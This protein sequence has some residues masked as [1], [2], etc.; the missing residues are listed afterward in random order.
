MKILIIGSWQ[1]D[2]AILSKKEAELIGK[3]LAEKEQ[4]LI[5]GGGEGVSEIVV[6]SYKKN[7][8]QKYVCYIPSKEQM[9]I[10]GEKIGP[11]PDELIETNLDYP[12]RNIKMVQ[13]C[14]AVIALNG[15][16]GTLTEII[17]AVKDYNKKVSVVDF[18]E[19]SSWIKAIPELHKKVLITSD[20]NRAIE[21]II[22]I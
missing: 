18:G 8:G 12:Q 15:G 22:T 21:Q 19:L 17:H 9:R 1:K 11:K 6:K 5:S 7:K 16:L 10:V 13:N 4:I 14:D 3:L 2:K 20:I